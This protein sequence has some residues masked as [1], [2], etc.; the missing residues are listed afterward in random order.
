MYT[1]ICF[2]FVIYA[3]V[4][5]VA[6]VDCTHVGAATASLKDLVAVARENSS[7]QT[8]VV[9]VENQQF[10]KARTQLNSR[11]ER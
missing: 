2:K 7:N 10:T 11:S 3:F 5:L 9:M 4:L 6:N 1:N 8:A